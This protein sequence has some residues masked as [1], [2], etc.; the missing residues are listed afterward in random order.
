MRNHPLVKEKAVHMGIGYDDAE[1]IVRA[2]KDA[3]SVAAVKQIDAARGKAKVDAEKVNKDMASKMG[4]TMDQVSTLV[5]KM[6]AC[7]DLETWLLRRVN[8]TRANG[9]PLSHDEHHVNE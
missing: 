2:Q 8:L 3:S 1:A 6:V 4:L 7:P 9:C 5:D